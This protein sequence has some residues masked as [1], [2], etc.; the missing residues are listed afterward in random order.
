MEILG[1]NNLVSGGTGAD[2]ITLSAAADQ[3]GASSGNLVYGGGGD[4]WILSITFQSTIHG[5]NGDDEI[6]I[7]NIVSGNRAHGG[8]GNDVLSVSGNQNHLS[9]DEGNDVLRSA[10]GVGWEGQDYP[11]NGSIL[12]G[13]P[14]IDR[15]ELHNSSIVRTG[16]DGTGT[17][18]EGMGLSGVMDRIA[19]YQAGEVV[20]IGAGTRHEGAVAIGASPRD[21]HG[22]RPLLNPGEY[23]VLHGENTSPGQFSIAENGPDMLIL[24]NREDGSGGTYAS[25]SVILNNS[26]GGG[27]VFA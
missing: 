2:R 9:G 27:L 13:G 22:L 18:V 14:G 5:G 1:S 4:D 17:L 20:D 8:K 24:Y 21:P 19:D 15:F 7:G 12:T 25:G 16:S 23:A 3:S 6:T 11:Q 26:D 10:S